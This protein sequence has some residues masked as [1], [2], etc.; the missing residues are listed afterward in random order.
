MVFDKS[1]KRN[2]FSPIFENDHMIKIMDNVGLAMIVAHE[3]LCGEESPWFAY[4]D[5]MPATFSTPLFYTLEE[6]EVI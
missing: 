6:L 3:L 4:L 5:T 2:I 1:F